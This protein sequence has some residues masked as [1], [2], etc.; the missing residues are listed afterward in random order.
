MSKRILSLAKA[1]AIIDVKEKPDKMLEFARG[2]G[3]DLFQK[4]EP[5]DK[6][7][8]LR[9]EDLAN[10]LEEAVAAIGDCVVILKDLGMDGEKAEE[11]ILGIVQNEIGG[12]EKI[13]GGLAEGKPDSDFDPAQLEKGVKV[14]LEHTDDVGTAKEIAKDHLTELPSDYYTRLEKME[15][16]ANKEQNASDDDEV[17]KY[18]KAARPL[19]H[20][21]WFEAIDIV[22]NFDKATKIAAATNHPLLA[23]LESS[24][25][26][27]KEWL[28]S[29]EFDVIHALE[30]DLYRYENPE[31][32]EEE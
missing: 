25:Q 16:K 4:G 13:P 12:S 15:E 5:N 9:A 18:I 21:V 6:D 20:N 11:Q 2:G 22:R 8:D 28:R 10:R 14:E 17:V 32:M 27:L 23:S 29:T 1:I 26:K 31:E 30:D 24:L 3:P 19:I 7:L